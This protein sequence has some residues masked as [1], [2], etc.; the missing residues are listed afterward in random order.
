MHLLATSTC[1]WCL[2]V[3]KYF[4]TVRT[5]F[6]I[7]VWYIYNMLHNVISFWSIVLYCLVL[8]LFLSSPK[9]CFTH[10]NF[11]FEFFFFSLCFKHTALF[12]KNAKANRELKVVWDST[13]L[14]RTSDRNG[15]YRALTINLHVMEQFLGVNNVKF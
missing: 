6:Y 12:C 3:I 14:W 5:P 15:L 9:F 10:I 1:W 11:N 4:L 13:I 7:A 8:I 2:S